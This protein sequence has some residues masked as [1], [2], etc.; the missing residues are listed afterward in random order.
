MSSVSSSRSRTFC[1][2]AVFAESNLLILR[3][4]NDVS[5]LPVLTRPPPTSLWTH[6]LWESQCRKR[7]ELHIIR[8]RHSRVLFLQLLLSLLNF[9][10]CWRRA[11]R[12]QS[13][14]KR[15]K[16]RLLSAVHVPGRTEPAHK[17]TPESFHIKS[18]KSKNS[19]NLKP[20]EWLLMCSSFS[21]CNPVLQQ[22]CLSSRRTQGGSTF[23]VF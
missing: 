2:Q 13:L 17:L 18:T 11:E 9:V 21:L 1:Q 8:R 15:G 5:N 19:S 10:S 3:L 16:S 4:K 20:K 23:A 12:L 14:F 22:N 7:Q 6:L